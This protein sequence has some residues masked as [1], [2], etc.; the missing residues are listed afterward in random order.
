MKATTRHSAIAHSWAGVIPRN[1][2]SWGRNSRR[3]ERKS[4]KHPENNK[5]KAVSWSS[6]R[7]S[8]TTT[9]R[10]LGLFAAICGGSVHR[11]A[12][13]RTP[14]GTEITRGLGPARERE[15]ESLSKEPAR[16]HPAALQEQL[17][18][19]PH[20]DGAHFE[21]PSARRQA[22]SDSPRA[23]QRGHALAVRKRIRR[24]EVHGST[25]LAPLKKPVDCANEVRVVDPGDVLLP[26]AGRAAEPLAHEPQDRV[27]DAAAV[28]AQDDR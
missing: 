23:P 22:H 7:P 14:A 9:S 5:A 28:R 16:D 21:H 25:C 15:R 18:L 8:A 27:E 10:R 19:G 2:M 13:L 1:A 24:G 26:V 3:I 6:S 20:E 4:A 17:G 11:P 12:A